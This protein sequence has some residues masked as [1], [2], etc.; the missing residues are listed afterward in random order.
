MSS[1]FYAKQDW[2]DTVYSQQLKVKPLILDQHRIT[3]K[4]TFILI[5]KIPISTIAW[6]NGSEFSDV[7]TKPKTTPPI[8]SIRLSDASPSWEFHTNTLF[9]SQ[10]LLYMKYH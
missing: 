1:S 7:K 4:H 10:H 8:R 2:Y 5:W 3:G 9:K 6:I